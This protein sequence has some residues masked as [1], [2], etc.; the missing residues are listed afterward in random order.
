MA[1]RQ[2]GF[3]LRRS[4]R[5]FTLPEVLI[6]II[7]MGVLLG[8][9][10]STWFRVA[11][12]RAV[13]SAANQ[14]ASDLRLAHAKATNQLTSYQVVFSNGSSSYDFGP[15]DSLKT[16]TLPESVKVNTALSTIEFK[17]SG[18]V[19]GPTGAANEIIVSKTSPATSPMHGISI[20]P[21]TSRV[22]ID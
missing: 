20:N 3:G 6:V 5:G 12:S 14:V 15:A 22:K 17:P 18:S 1:G 2:S 16:R 8:I 9:A 11:E 7:I 10:T 19:V 21:V 13:D 4:E